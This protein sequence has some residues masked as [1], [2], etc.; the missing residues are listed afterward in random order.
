[1]EKQNKWGGNCDEK[2]DRSSGS[3]DDLPVFGSGE[4]VERKSSV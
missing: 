4:R 1:M 3:D 2:I